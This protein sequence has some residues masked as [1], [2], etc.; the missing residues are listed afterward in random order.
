MWHVRRRVTYPGAGVSEATF[1]TSEPK[2]LRSRASFERV[3]DSAIRLLEERGSADF[4]LVEVSQL[5]DAS[6]GSIYGRVGSKDDLIRIVQLR[7]NKRI[8]EDH[9]KVL[10]RAALNSTG[11]VSLVRAL[12]TGLAEFLK[13]NAPI[14]R[15][16]MSC[17]SSDPVI[18]KAG[19]LSHAKFA[20]AFVE[21]V[22]RY[23]AEINHPQPELAAEACFSIAYATLAR[24]LGLGTEPT[25]TGGGPWT[26][27]K[28]HLCMMSICFLHYA[29]SI[30]AEEP[31]RRRRTK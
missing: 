26:A 13:R 1:L 5:A 23:R 14:L 7:V 27:L 8:E 21:L 30:P 19:K 25:S 2:Q 12:V 15:A 16:L 4:T 24:Y 11:L 3:I 20:T 9:N 6:I 17:A 29:A 18:E 28:E 31:V 10:E 22:L